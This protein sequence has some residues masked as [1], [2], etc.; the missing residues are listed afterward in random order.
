MV[1]GQ[2]NWLLKNIFP[3]V[4]VPLILLAVSASYYQFIFQQD[5][6]V[7]FQGYCDP[8][9]ESCFWG[10]YENFDDCSDLQIEERAPGCWIDYH[11]R[12]VAK[13]F[14][15]FKTQMSQC[16]D[17]VFFDLSEEGEHVF[18]DPS[19][20]EAVDS[21]DCGS[22]TECEVEYCDPINPLNECSK[23]YVN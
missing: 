12:L 15:V 18:S 17:P 6:T 16:T 1:L 14:S 23:H 8:E 4:L 11:Y 13:P 20:C 10:E 5:Y 7:T 9:V 19:F 21:H 3:I 2:M 22:L